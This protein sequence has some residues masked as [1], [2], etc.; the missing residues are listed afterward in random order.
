M[1]PFAIISNTN[2]LPEPEKFDRPIQAQYRNFMVLIGDSL[3]GMGSN[4]YGQLGTG[5]TTAQLSLTLCKTG[6]KKFFLGTSGTIIV[7]LDD[8]IYWA[9]RNTCFP[10]AGTKLS[11]FDVTSL[12]A[13]VQV[14]SNNLYDCQIGESIRIITTDGRFIYTGRNG[15]GECGVSTTPVDTLSVSEVSNIFKISATI[16][17]T[18]LISSDGTA[19]FCGLNAY[20]ESG[21]NHKDKITSITYVTSNVKEISTSYNST[22][23]FKNDGTVWC[24]GYNLYG[25]LANGNNTSI[26]IITLNTSIP[27]LDTSFPIIV[28]NDLGNASGVGPMLLSNNS[29]LRHSG[30]NSVGNIGR[31]NIGGPAQTT[32]YT[33]SLTE[34]GGYDNIKGIAKHAYGTFV[35]TS[36]NRLFACGGNSESIFG[37]LPNGGSKVSTMTLMEGM[38]WY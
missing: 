35:L 29:S 1:L 10:Q 16:D 5:N 18:H 19:Y 24:S 8:K 7:G 36:D 21:L 2:I 17:C 37:I 22:Q 25:Q 3:Y 13:S 20:G 15:Y 11:W 28:T 26:Q 4:N 30:I 12:F 23:W 31:G 6:V 14:N 34:I 33:L 9:G 27:T 38:P 32:L